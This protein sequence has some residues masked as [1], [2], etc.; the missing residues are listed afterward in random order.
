MLHDTEC[1]NCCNTAVISGF[2]NDSEDYSTIPH[3]QKA[4]KRFLKVIDCTQQLCEND[5]KR[6]E[7]TIMR[8]L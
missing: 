5:E 6:Y 7:K 3:F 4:L 1:A 8:N 2:Q